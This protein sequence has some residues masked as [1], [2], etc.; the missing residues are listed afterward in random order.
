MVLALF[1]FS[2][3]FTA[4]PFM[5]SLILLLILIWHCA[6]LAFAWERRL[7]IC[8]SCIWAASWQNQQNDCAP[9]K[10]WDQPGHTPSLIRVFVV[11]MKRAWILSYPLSAQRR[12]WSD[13][14]DA[15]ADL[16]L[17]WLHRPVCWFCHEAA[18]LFVYL[19]C[20]SFWLFIVL[21]LGVRD[22]MR[23][24]TVALPGLFI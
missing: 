21:H 9:S 5:L 16:S 18:H 6:R 17:H 11:R 7:P 1:L 14:A 24:V 8:S 2:V 10:D 15:Q 13:W 3:V 4:M 19:A 12:L 20:V 23:L 22:L